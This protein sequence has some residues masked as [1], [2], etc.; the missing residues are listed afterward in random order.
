MRAQLLILVTVATT[1][2]AQTTP[3]DIRA[4]YQEKSATVVKKINDT[5]LRQGTAI[6]AQLVAKGDTAGAATV[7]D[8]LAQKTAF[9]FGGEPHASLAALFTQYDHARLNALKPIQ[10]ASIAKIEAALK[11][12][13]GKDLLVITEYGKLRA[14]IEVGKLADEADPK[15]HRT[16]SYHVN[17]DARETAWLRLLPEGVLEWHDSNATKSG[18]WKPKPNGILIDFENEKWDVAIKGKMA[19]IQGR[20]V[21]IRY[22]KAKDDP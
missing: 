13:A 10:A 16:W 4:D 11:T 5:L 15:M 14:E 1:A 17:P 6:A 2:M 12:S 21:G 9:N 19:T 22:L 8:Q 3:A 18:T 7:S 20:S